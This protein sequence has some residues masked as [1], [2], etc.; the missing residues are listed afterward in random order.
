MLARTRRPGC[1][2]DSTSYTTARVTSASALFSVCVGQ[3][4]ERLHQ[5]Q[6]GVDHRRELAGE[7]D[8]VARLDPRAAQAE[9]DLLRRLAGRLTRI[10]RFFRR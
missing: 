3:D 9:L 5:R 8:D 10:S 1:C 6:A 7:D 2:R 4:V